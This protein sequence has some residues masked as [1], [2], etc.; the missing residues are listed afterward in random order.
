MNVHWK[1][2]YFHNIINFFVTKFHFIGYM[3]ENKKDWRKLPWM[4]LRG[5]TISMQRR[6]I[7]TC[8]V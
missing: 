6:C 8:L 4:K 2:G 5:H 1:I 3:D 7:N